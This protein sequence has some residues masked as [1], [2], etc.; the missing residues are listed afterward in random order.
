MGVSY[1][2]TETNFVYMDF[3]QSA[4][5]VFEKLLRKGVIIRPLGVQNRPT[6][7][8]ITIGTPEQNARTLDELEAA[9]RK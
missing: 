9:L 4:A 7:A 5:D 8:R 6:C 3:H 1:L 2:P